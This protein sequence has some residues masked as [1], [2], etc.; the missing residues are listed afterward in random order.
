ML[1]LTPTSTVPYLLKLDCSIEVGP[2]SIKAPP[3]Y[4]DI[5]GYEVNIF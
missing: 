2:S 1:H 5:T 3:K 4:C